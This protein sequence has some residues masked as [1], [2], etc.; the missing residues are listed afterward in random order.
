MTTKQNE[1]EIVASR[2][3]WV[4]SVAWIVIIIVQIA[5][6]LFF[7]NYLGFS[8]LLYIGGCLLA[9]FFV[10]CWMA[11]SEFNRKGGIPQGKSCMYTTVVVDSGIYSVVRH[12]MY[13]G[14]ILLVLSIPLFSQ[15]WLSVA[16]GTITAALIYSYAVNEDKRLVKKFGEEYK[17]YMETVPRVNLLVGIYGLLS[18]KK[19]K[20]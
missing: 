16:L 3:E 1:T 20:K 12:P 7:F 18:N 9:T 4:I 2:K 5:I 11:R 17:N 8:V 15:H 6:P 14:W 19:K 13:T 10:I